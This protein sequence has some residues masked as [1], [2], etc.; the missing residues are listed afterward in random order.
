MYFLLLC[1]HIICAI[2]F[3]GYVFF[4]AV[5]FPFAYKQCSEEYCNCVKKSYTKA[6]GALFGIIFICLLASGGMLLRYYDLKGIFSTYFGIF[7][8]IKLFLIFCMLAITVYAVS[9]IRFLKKEDPF[10]GKSHLIALVISLLIV[11]LAKAMGY[12]G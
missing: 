11:I 2:C 1:L 7:L 6:S 3:V 4:D 5:I 10:K 9:R 8:S 12:Y